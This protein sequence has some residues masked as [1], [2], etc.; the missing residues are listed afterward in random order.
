MQF[1]WIILTLSTFCMVAITAGAG[2]HN[3]DPRQH[4]LLYNDCYNPS[5]T[6]TY[7]TSSFCPQTSVYAVT[8]PPTP[9]Q[10]RYQVLTPTIV[11]QTTGFRCQKKG[12]TITGYC[13][14]Y[15]HFK[16]AEVPTFQAEEAMTG[17]EC[18]KLA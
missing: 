1:H 8:P 5:A 10:T 9:L 15:S 12:S 14:A 4:N 7:T 6:A 2:P 11:R 16:W 3:T 17:E 18:R 13:G